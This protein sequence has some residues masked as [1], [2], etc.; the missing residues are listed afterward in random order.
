M[1]VNLSE[2]LADARLYGI[3]DLGYVSIENALPMARKMMEG[4]V[5]IL[6]LRA[7]KQTEENITAL[8]KKLSP[9]CREFGVPFILNDHPH[10]VPAMGAD[11]VHIGQDDVSVA[12]A[13]SLAGPAAIVGKSTHRVAQAT[14]AAA[15][16]ADYLGFGPLFATPTKP[17]YTPIGLAEIAEAHRLVPSL[18][19]FCI[20]GIKRE[21]LDKV[22]MA[23]A[24][25]VVI[26]SGILQADD[27]A[28][29]CR[30]CRGRLAAQP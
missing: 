11:G 19:I 21:N 28:G 18:S 30:D 10:L 1:A 17:D 5:Q 2:N 24:Q 16:G 29:Y 23:G 3:L 20:G 25:R 8:G 14:A 6:Q 7:K 27:V 13:R 4:G 15:E 22:L 12:E 26:V 9:L